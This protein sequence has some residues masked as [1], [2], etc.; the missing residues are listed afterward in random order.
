MFDRLAAIFSD[1]KETPPPGAD[2]LR[3]AAAILLVE[4]ARMDG[5]FD[6]DERATIRTLLTWRFEISNGDADALI[7]AA[8]AEAEQLVELSTYV[9]TIRNRF[10]HDERVEL[11]EMMWT[12]VYSDRKLDDY[13]ANLMR[14]VAG[15]LYV[16]DA[17]SGAARK[18]VLERLDLADNTE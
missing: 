15:L 18:R 10:S 12:V 14:R 7:A 4:A 16:S 9:R 2:S 17:E 11:I 3:L 6:A 1:D 8:N 5:H 13:E